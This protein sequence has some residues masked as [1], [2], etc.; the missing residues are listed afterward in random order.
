MVA[1]TVPVCGEL[2]VLVMSALTV[3]AELLRSA[4]LLCST[5]ALLSINAPPT[6]S[7]TG[8]W[9]PVLLSGGICVQSTL[10]SVYIE[11]GSFGCISIASELVPFT[12]RCV[13]S[14]ANRVYAPVTVAEVAT[15]WPLT[16]TSAA[17]T[18]PL[19][20]KFACWPGTR[21]RVK[22][23]RNHQGT[24]NC[25]ILSGPIFF[26]KPKHVFTL[27][28]KYTFGHTPFCSRASISVPGAPASS[29]VTAS[30]PPV[31]NPG[32]EIC[33]PDWVAV[34]LVSTFQPADPRSDTALEPVAVAAALCARPTRPVSEPDWLVL[35]A[36]AIPE[37]AART[38]AA[39]T[40]P[41]RTTRFM[42]S[43]PARG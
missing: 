39:A 40:R 4:P 14:K 28:E 10:S 30:Q 12:S 11:V 25:L 37:L 32:V 36:A 16:H 24:L 21:S 31:L 3:S 2:A 33:C 41:D 6:C 26:M 15:C 22:S 8:N 7:W 17:P 35:A 42:V 23:V 19:T 38:A 13:M 1:V 43:T 20:I 34:A 18:T 27:V 9:M 29:F 5:C